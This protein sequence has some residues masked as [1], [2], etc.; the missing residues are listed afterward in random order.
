MDDK[1]QNNNQ[2]EEL[3]LK[4][5]IEEYEDYC[6]SIKKFEKEIEE[7]YKSIA[8]I[9]QK[10]YDKNYLVELTDF[11]HF[12][13]QIYYN[14][15]KTDVKSYRDEINFKFAMLKSQNQEVKQEKLKQKIINSIGELF[16]LLKEEHQYILINEE[17]GKNF[18]ENK[19]EANYPYSLNSKELIINIKEQSLSFEHNKNIIN[20]TSL[21]N[22][23]S[24]ILKYQDQEYLGDGI[25]IKDEIKDGTNNEAKDYIQ[26][27]TINGIKDD[28]KDETILINNENNNNII[29]LEDN[30]QLLDWF[31]K[32]Y[33]E[34]K[35]FKTAI[36]KKEKNTEYKLGFLIDQIE[37]NK[38]E[39]N[40]NLAS[41]REILKN[42]L[43]DKENLTEDDKKQI[44]GNLKNNNI[45]KK[46]KIQSLKFKSIEELKAFNKINNLILLNKELYFLINESEEKN[47]HENIIQYISQDKM[48]EI[49]INDSKASFYRFENFI[50][51][52]MYY[53]IY[54]L[55]KIYI[56]QKNLQT[57]KKTS[58][59][60]LLNKEMFEKY[61]EC[62]N[63]KIF[64]QLIKNSNIYKKENEKQICE[65]IEN[66]IPDSYINSIKK[67]V[68]SFKLDLK[69]IS[70]KIV[71]Q[72]NTI[73]FAY[74]SDFDVLFLE[75]GSFINFYKINEI[76]KDENAMKKLVKIFFIKEKILII[77]DHEKKTFGQI[78]T[79]NNSDE[80][81]EFLI[82]YLISVK[83][84]KTGKIGIYL[85]NEIFQKENDDNIF[86]DFIYKTNHEEQFE[87]TISDKLIF[88]VLNFRK[89]KGQN[90]LNNENPFFVNNEGTPN[91]EKQQTNNINQN[92]IIIP[93]SNNIQNNNFSNNFPINNQAQPNGIF[94]SNSIEQNNINNHLNLDEQSLATNPFRVKESTT[95]DNGINMN[96]NNQ[97]NMVTNPFHIPE[98][99]NNNEN[100]G[101]VINMNMNN[102][103]NM[104]FN[105]FHIREKQNSNENNG[106]VINMNL[107]VGHNELNG[108]TKVFL[109]NL[110][111]ININNSQMDV[112]NNNINNAINININLNQNHQ[113]DNSNNNINNNSNFNQNNNNNQMNNINNMSNM[114][115]SNNNINNNFNNN[116]NNNPKN[117]IYNTNNQ[118]PNNNYPNQIIVPQ[119][120]F[121][122]IYNY[123][124]LIISFI[125]SDQTIKLKI[126]NSNFD[127]E[128]LYLI[129]NQWLLNFF[130]IFK[131]CEIDNIIYSNPNIMSM[132][133][134]DNNSIAQNIFGYL[135]DN[136]KQYL[137]NLDYN[138]LLAQLNNNLTII[139]QQNL[140]VNGTFQNIFFNFYLL[141]EN[142]VNT[143]SLFININLQTCL[144][145]SE[146]ILINQNI[147]AFINDNNMYIGK[148]G[149]DYL[150][151]PQ[152]IIYYQNNE[153]KNE[154]KSLVQTDGINFLNYLY[155]SGE[156]IQNNF[157][158]QII[159]INQFPIKR[160]PIINRLTVYIEFENFK[161]KLVN[162][163]NNNNDSQEEIVLINKNLLSKINYD[164]IINIINKYTKQIGKIDDIKNLLSNI[165]PNLSYDDIQLLKQGFNQINFGGLKKDDILSKP[166]NIESFENKKISVYNDFLAVKK[167]LIKI[168][169]KKDINQKYLYKIISGSGINIIVINNND[170]K[171]L[172]IGNI[173]NKENTF[174]LLYILNFKY[175][176]DLESALEKIK[177]NYT[178]Y[179]MKYLIFENED[180]KVSPI[181]NKEGKIVGYG[182]KYDDKLLYNSLTDYYLCDNLKNVILLFNYFNFLNDW[183][184]I[185]NNKTKLGEHDYCLVSKKWVQRFKETFRYENIT[186]EINSGKEIENIIKENN[187]DNFE[188]NDKKI[189]SVL[190]KLNVNNYLDYNKDLK[191]KKLE[192]NNYDIA[193]ELTST[194]YIDSFNQQHQF[195]VYNEFEILPRKLIEKYVEHIEDTFYSCYIM[196]SFIIINF[197]NNL[198]GNDK[199]ISLIGE[200]NY[201]NSLEIKTVLIYFHRFQKHKILEEENNDL[202]NLIGIKEK[203]YFLSKNE[204]YDTE[205]MDECFAI[206]FIPNKIMI[207]NDNNFQVGNN[208]NGF[209]NDNNNGF[210]NDNNNG[211]NND[212]NNGFNNDGFNNDDN[213]IDDNGLVKVNV[214]EYCLDHQVMYPF[215]KNNF[216]FPPLKG[217]DNIGATCYMNATLQ[218][219]CNIEQFV[220]FLKYDKNLIYK[221]QT[222]IDKKTLSSSFKL[223]IEKLW[224]NDYMTNTKKSYSPYEFKAKI[225]FM[226][227]LFKGVAANDSKD[228]VNFIIMT[229]H[230]E[231]NM[232]TNQI[233]D[234]TYNIDQTNM[235][236]MYNSFTQTFNANNQSEIS[237]LFY[238]F[239]YNVTQCSNCHTK[240]FNF[241]T[242]FF[243][244][245]PLEEIRKFKLNNNQ[246]NNF[247]NI[248]DNNE[249]NIYDCLN[250]DRKENMMDGSNMM[251]CNYCKL[252]CPS[253]MSTHLCTGPEILI[254]ILNRGKGIQFNVKINFYETLDLS[255]YIG[256]PN[257]G[258]FYNLIGV[259]THIGE[260][261]MGGHFIAYCRN[262]INYKWNKYNDSIVNAVNDFKS[263]VIDF[264][265]PYLLFYQKQH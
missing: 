174:Q 205:E 2:D 223:L 192:G 67:N 129:N 265:M 215:V 55:T 240:S 260:S 147:Y 246:F 254:I 199:Y 82:D 18:V 208:N 14:L 164:Y 166:Q 233:V 209:N 126:N 50:C 30:F 159:N 135:S 3:R 117:N 39:K 191:D 85:A 198:N 124:C 151:Y 54:L 75:G 248:I 105:P 31:V 196:N 60:Y 83:E 111:K 22:K 204:S 99:Q 37:Y 12:K 179:L 118:M 48:V 42:S 140:N 149:T 17:F 119:Y 68:N 77:F 243:L 228:L 23:Q 180:F 102:Q 234:N 264:A 256:M 195:F 86:Y 214:I 165:I 146:C 45:T 160:N 90:S 158:L 211:F 71:K 161:E 251:Y 9:H 241:Q 34:E 127:L 74:L 51:S 202:K 28:I 13:E 97:Q 104:A 69:L 252:T 197:P 25:S 263:E 38:W 138:Y 41:L 79:I 175:S 65:F 239:N 8:I 110:G 201:N 262:P 80:Q 35:E 176:H 177:K 113:F 95:K 66:K 11:E 61:K 154:I 152:T 81:N 62:F 115:N 229:L 258:Y 182:Y 225:S 194:G 217:L 162:D 4:I 207:N 57:E 212:G 15:F 193:P 70:T 21:K 172:L 250:Y 5:I 121:N 72:N 167:D 137:N 227:E 238:A 249:V 189:F 235:M 1:N 168:I 203:R 27:A 257:T 94:T 245:F 213:V 150:F 169:T 133:F 221:V 200:M 47:N 109:N 32:Y 190:N 44:I 186:T 125:Q 73:D 237:R 218:C 16:N 108:E 7:N 232:A 148:L 120:D 222:D 130:Q 134:N 183:N 156:L 142:F 143:L 139:N 255:G 157:N 36:T 6:M 206:D 106:N 210:N 141:G 145:K 96:M 59:I 144:L 123:L 101:N 10:N 64:K 261:G 136:T 220:N 188:S 92:N 33:L 76:N 89:N 230:E 43:T 52:Y 63:Y 91:P 84:N 88:Y 56:Y 49:S 93:N 20:Y 242:Y 24:E 253:S 178:S 122:K 185:H 155:F 132:S 114:N 153:V 98:K 216:R 173:I 87:Y 26:D 46:Y 244:I 128:N 184:N 171:T 226:N 78:G 40:M 247:N 224:P 116:P 100:N 181:F 58:V 236:F 219:F 170:E 259:I 231:L 103:Q 131:T 187:G 163:T 29:N 53:N 112:S 107:N 19:H